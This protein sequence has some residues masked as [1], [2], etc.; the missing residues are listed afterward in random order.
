[1]ENTIKKDV[2]KAF[3]LQGEVISC[4]RYGE[5]HINET[6]KVVC[7]SGAWYILQKL[8]KTAFKRPD[9]LME[10]IANVTEFL[11]KHVNSKREAL[12]LVK[13]QEGKMYHVDENGEYYRVYDFIMDSYALQ[14]AQSP[15]DFYESAVAFG[16]FQKLLSAYPAENLYE[17]I[18]NFHN[19]PVRFENL[20]V[21][22]EKD[23]KDR[24]KTCQ[25]EIDGFLKRKCEAATLTDLLSKGKLPL[26]VTH[27]DTKLNNVLMDRTTRKAACVIDLDTVMAGLVAY[28]FGDS[29]RFGASTALEDETD[30][31]KVSMD[32]E[33]FRTYT[34][35]FLSACGEALT[36]T[37]INTLHWGAKLMTLE[38]G[39]RFLTDYLDG[40][41]YFRIH[42][43]NHNLDRA[44]TQLKLVEDMETKFEQMLEIVQTTA[45]K[46]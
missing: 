44:R 36:E 22:I 2:L 11:Q 45:K 41:N 7:E 34:E 24:V 46:Y 32:I 21:A 27:N 3:C 37:E 43:E 25:K 16:N 39:A 23:V 12:S 5:G 1:M 38:C 10:N 19:T 29:I 4:E 26:K 9:Q 6:Y 17:T 40:D 14:M 15:D 35:G 20:L 33:L 31:S 18:V 42:R 28:D 13:T 8:S 30:L